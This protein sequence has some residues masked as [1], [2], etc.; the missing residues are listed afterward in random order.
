MSDSPP[1]RPKGGAGHPVRTSPG[2][3]HLPDCEE[4]WD[5]NFELSDEERRAMM[6]SCRAAMEAQRAALEGSVDAD[7]SGDLDDTEATALRALLRDR[8]RSGC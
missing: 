3:T 8:I 7:G 4:P 1:R 2:G 6:E 5:V